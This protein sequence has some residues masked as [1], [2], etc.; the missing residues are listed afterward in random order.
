M[1]RVLETLPPM[2]ETLMELL[3]PDFSLVQ[4]WAVAR[5]GIW[6]VSRWIED[7]CKYVTLPFK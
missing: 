4:P 1:T 7:L 3:V 6:R 2:R 5:Q